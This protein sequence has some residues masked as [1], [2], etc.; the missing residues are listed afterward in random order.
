MVIYVCW[1]LKVIFLPDARFGYEIILSHTE[2][3]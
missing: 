2:I 3:V 1:Y